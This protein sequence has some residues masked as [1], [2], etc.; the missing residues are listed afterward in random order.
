MP[1][2][3]YLDFNEG[4]SPIDDPD[5]FNVL[6]HL[7]NINQPPQNKDT[8]SKNWQGIFEGDLVVFPSLLS[9]AG[10][11]EAVRFV[12]PKTIW[13]NEEVLPLLTAGIEYPEF[14]TLIVQ[15]S[16]GKG[17]SLKDMFEEP[18]N[19]ILQSTPPKLTLFDIYSRDEAAYNE[20]WDD[21]P[22]AR[23]RRPPSSDLWEIPCG[24]LQFLRTIEGKSLV[25][26]K[27]DEL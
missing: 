17:V 26:K 9:G 24:E 22:V 2:V 15:L 3:L 1:N 6:W 5:R 16:E 14:P 11:F 8:S 21:P 4:N 19:A 20:F 23:R 27:G 25:E 7:T 12:G 18:F 10:E 13:K